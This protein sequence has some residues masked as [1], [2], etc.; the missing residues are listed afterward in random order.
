[1]AVKEGRGGGSGPPGVLVGR[2]GGPAE[3]NRAER[4]AGPGWAEKRGGVREW[5]WVFLKHFFFEHLF[6]TS[7]SS[8]IFSKLFSKFSNKL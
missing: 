8:H 3:K 6:Q 4:V 7:N 5:F 1:V 2:R